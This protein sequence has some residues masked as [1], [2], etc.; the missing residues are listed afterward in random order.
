MN[1]FQIQLSEK[2][3]DTRT[4]S[5]QIPQINKYSLGQKFTPP[6]SVSFAVLAIQDF[7]FGTLPW[8]LVIRVKFGTC[9]QNWDFFGTKIRDLKRKHTTLL[10][11][12]LDA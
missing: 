11:Y 3:I 12:L 7:E 6:Y 10:I 9:V 1:K 5:L 4:H 2:L 8:H